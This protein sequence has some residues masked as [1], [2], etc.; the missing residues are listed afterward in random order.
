MSDQVGG[1]GAFERFRQARD[2]SASNLSLAELARLE[3]GW[4]EEA[5]RAVR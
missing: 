3:G 5:P 2:G 4:N 1:D